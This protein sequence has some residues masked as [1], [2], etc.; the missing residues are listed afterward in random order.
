MFVH[1][2]AAEPV[3]MYLVPAFLVTLAAYASTGLLAR[4]VLRLAGR[5]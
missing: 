5:K 4:L 2:A 1:G 3:Q